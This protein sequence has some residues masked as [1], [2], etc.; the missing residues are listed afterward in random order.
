[1]MDGKYGREIFGGFGA[2]F[3]RHHARV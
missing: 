2:N 1:V 3:E